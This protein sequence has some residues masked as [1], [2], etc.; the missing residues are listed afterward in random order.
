MKTLLVK[1]L[2]TPEGQIPVGAHD[3]N[4][5]LM[6]LKHLKDQKGNMDRRLSLQGWMTKNAS[7]MAED[8]LRQSLLT[9]TEKASE[10]DALKDATVDSNRLLELLAKISGDMQ[11][12]TLPVLHEAIHTL[13]RKALLE[14]PWESCRQMYTLSFC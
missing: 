5:L 12:G 7:H 13:M 14:V 9:F 4:T 1:V 3:I 11:G 2:E 6:V 8:D 10:V